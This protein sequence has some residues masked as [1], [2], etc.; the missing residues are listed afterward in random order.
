MNVDCLALPEPS[1]TVVVG[2]SGGV[3]STLVT[4]LLKE[5]GCHVIG[6]TMSSWNNDLD[7]ERSSNGVRESCYG[8]DED[9]DIATCKAFCKEIGIAHYT[10][11]V[12]ASY[13]KYVL[14]YVKSEYK[15]GKTP[16]PCVM[17]NP[18]VKFGA[19]LSG[20]DALG[21]Q[22]DYFCTGHYARLMRPTQKIA[23][24][25]QD[26]P[27]TK[28]YPLLIANGVD[29]T[30]DQTYFLNRLPSS[31]LEKVRFPLGTMHKKDVYALARQKNLIA[32]ERKESQD[33]IPET[34][35]EK[36]FADNPTKQGDIVLLDGTVVGKHR[37]I[38]YYTIGQRRGLGV[39]SARPLYVY[40]ID[41][42]QN[43]VVL[44]HDEDLLCEG[45]Y[46]NNFVWAGGFVPKEPFSARVKIRLA[47]PAVDA[48]IAPASDKN[49]EG[50]FCV[51]FNE[52]L[53][54]VAPG[55]ALVIYVDEMIIG[56]GIITQKI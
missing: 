55:Q 44:A 54:A 16:N 13:R 49:D 38:Q 47:T 23:P 29:V 8:P 39:S 6:A 50:V 37:G 31:L 1:S 32:A 42:V 35:F 21:V 33:F 18:N 10:V 15:N 2:M 48:V 20:L 28:N 24:F 5:H 25:W 52:P 19:L 22:F 43:Q 53:R 27:T 30:K 7:L 41:A 11:D 26:L 51:R 34:Y 3:D 4:L 45:L 9:I 12:R 14:D 56:G 46:A 36:L 17:C 40:A